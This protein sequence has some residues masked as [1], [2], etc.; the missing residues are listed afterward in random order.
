M[1]KEYVFSLN[2]LYPD[3]YKIVT[4]PLSKHLLG[5]TIYSITFI[6]KNYVIALMLNKKKN[7]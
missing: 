1:N 2:N 7:L 4:L 6:R 3:I 5:Y